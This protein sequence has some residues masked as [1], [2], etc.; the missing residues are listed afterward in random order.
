MHPEGCP[1][2]KYE[3]H[4]DRL[5]VLF[6]EVSSLVRELLQNPKNFKQATKDTRPIH[7]RCFQKLTPPG[8]QYYAGHYRGENFRC[9]QYCQVAAG[10]HEGYP[11]HLVPSSMER[12]AN[13]IDFAL[14]Q[15]DKAEKRMDI[16]NEEKLLR[17]VRVACRVF[18]Q[19]CTIHPYLNGNGHSA[20]FCMWAV[21]GRYG[22]LP[23]GWPIEPRPKPQDQY[24]SLLV[25]YRAGNREPLER[26][27][28][29]LCLPI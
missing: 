8:Y 3:D 25:E 7:F 2:W 12:L 22:F 23:W 24:I 14:T 20:R 9:L 28:L 4:P 29:N 11:P 1:A 6:N 18:E 5:T 26:H 27:I 10:T 16:P 15:L 21:L 19:I 13:I 17:I